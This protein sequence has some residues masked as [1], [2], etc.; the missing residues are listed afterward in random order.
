MAST[1]TGKVCPVTLA[2][3]ELLR[4]RVRGLLR[5]TRASGAENPHPQPAL[6]ASTAP[7]VTTTRSLGAPDGAGVSR[8]STRPPWPSGCRS[9]RRDDGAI[10]VIWALALASLATL[11]AIV[12]DIG[13]LVQSTAN[14]QDASDSVAISEANLLVPYL[15]PDGLSPRRPIPG[16]LVVGAIPV[17]RQ[18]QCRQGW[19]GLLSCANMSWLDSYYLYEPLPGAGLSIDQVVA[20]AARSPGEISELGA[21]SDLTGTGSWECARWSSHQ[22]PGGGPMD[23]CLRLVPVQ[24][25]WGPLA[26]GSDLPGGT[27]TFSS[28][29]REAVALAE[30]AYGEAGAWATCSGPPAGFAASTAA[31][32]CTAYEVEATGAVVVWAN[33]RKA[34]GWLIASGPLSEVQRSSWATTGGPGSP[35]TLCT[36]PPDLGGSCP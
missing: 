23:D 8:S 11:L 5:T 34:P 14:L 32:A 26:V 6:K 1:T 25:G 33:A 20:G 29:S 13:D 27:P 36:G 2:K 31:P 18:A 28:V 35:A 7:V 30:R 24:P 10:L 9:W 21:F 3:P 22:W 12:V 16:Q 4:S 15:V 19:S 17:P